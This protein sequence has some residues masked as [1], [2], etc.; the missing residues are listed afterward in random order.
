MDSPA[1]FLDTG[2]LGRPSCPGTHHVDQAGLQLTEHH[3]P[4]PPE[5]L[6]ERHRV[7]IPG[8]DSPLK[9]HFDICFMLKLQHRTCVSL[10]DM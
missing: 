10:V 9:I 8:L 4:L 5:F 1:L 2:S 3:F 7:T 6:D